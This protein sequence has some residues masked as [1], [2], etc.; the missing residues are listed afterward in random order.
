[1]RRG[2]WLLG[3]ASRSASIGEEVGIAMLRDVRMTFREP[4]D[5]FAFTRFDGSRVTI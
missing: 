5:G 2:R 3:K 4:F 1:M